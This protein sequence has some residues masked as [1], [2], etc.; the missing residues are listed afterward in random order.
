MAHSKRRSFSDRLRDL[1]EALKEAL[2]P[3]QPAPVP[4]PVRDDW[5]LRRR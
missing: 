3:R 2:S 1:L 5:Y 4:I